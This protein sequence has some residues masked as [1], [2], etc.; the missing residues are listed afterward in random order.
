[1]DRRD[2]FRADIAPLS[3]YNHPDQVAYAI[4]VSL[5]FGYM[6][7]ETP[8]AA[9]STIKRFL[10]KNELPDIHLF[11]DPHADYETFEYLHDRT[12]SPLLNPKQLYPFLP[13]LTD[14]SLFRFCFVRHPYD[15]LLSAYLDKILH[16]RYEAKAIKAHWGLR[17]DDPNP[18]SF[19]QFIEAVCATPVHA[20]DA[21]WRV[22][23][24]FNCIDDIPY[25]F[26]GRVDRFKGDIETICQR[27]GLDLSH[28]QRFAPHRSDASE[29]LAAYYDDRLKGMVQWAF[30]MDFAHF[31]FAP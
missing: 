4:N 5:R 21:H 2:Y 13:R 15:R 20:M 7:Y 24:Y 18:V 28:L 30:H 29:R 8:K 14:G 12:Y 3:R 19:A 22:Q 9:C 27:T 31:D 1:M 25:D 10:I 26:I 16:D 23:Y 17:P 6:Y 11:D